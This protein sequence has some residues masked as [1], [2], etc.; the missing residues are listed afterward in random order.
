M[1]SKKGCRVFHCVF[2]FTNKKGFISQEIRFSRRCCCVGG[3]AGVCLC[4]V[5]LGSIIHLGA[6]C[7]A[8][9]GEGLG[10]VTER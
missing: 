9:R 3:E 2:Y 5:I 4:A 7:R 1:G 10:G 6:F 8:E